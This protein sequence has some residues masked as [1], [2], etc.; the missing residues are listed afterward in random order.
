M[1][2]R[3]APQEELF[4]Y[5]YLTLLIKLLGPRKRSLGDVIRPLYLSFFPMW[6]YWLTLPLLPFTVAFLFDWLMEDSG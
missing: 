5:V 4:G 3:P 1:M 2:G 6:P